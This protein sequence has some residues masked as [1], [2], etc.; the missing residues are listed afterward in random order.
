MAYSGILAALGTGAT[1]NSAPFK[2]PG[3]RNSVFKHFGAPPAQP[4]LAKARLKFGNWRI[5]EVRY[6]PD[7]SVEIAGGRRVIPAVL[8]DGEPGAPGGQLDL[9]RNALTLGRLGVDAPLKVNGIG[10]YVSSM[11]SLGK[12]RNLLGKAQCKLFRG[13]NGGLYDTSAPVQWRVALSLCGGRS[14]SIWPTLNPSGE[15]SSCVGRCCGPELVGSRHVVMKPHINCVHASAHQLKRELVDSDGETMGLSGCGAEV[16]LQREVCREYKKRS[17]F[18]D[19]GR[20][21]RV[22]R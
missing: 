1:A 21:A 20:P 4:R 13:L 7:I 12:E 16:L 8:H 10:H 15:R 17:A 9:F 22:A 19:C 14:I 6:A 5:G 18:A 3:R 11:A 2:W